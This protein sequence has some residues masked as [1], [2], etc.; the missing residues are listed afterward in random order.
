M[1][2]QISMT[3]RQPLGVIGGI[4]PVNSPFLL[5]I[6]KISFVLKPSELAPLSG[7][8]I[9]ECF[10]LAGLPPGV[11]NVAPVRRRWW[12]TSSSPIRA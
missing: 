11:L 5:S 3:I 2:G 1:P 6:K 12:A 8:K 10:E 4:A 9:A 7:L